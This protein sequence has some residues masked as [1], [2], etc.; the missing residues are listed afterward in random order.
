MCL[1][2]TPSHGRAKAGWPDR[3]YIQQLCADTGCSPEELPEAMDDGELGERGLGISVP[4]ARH[5]DDDDYVLDLKHSSWILI[6]QERNLE[7]K[8]G[9]RFRGW[10]W[11]YIWNWR[12]RANGKFDWMIYFKGG[13]SCFK[14]YEALI[15]PRIEYCTRA[16]VQVSRHRNWIWFGLVW[17]YGI[18]TNAKSI[19]IHI[20]S[21]ISNDSV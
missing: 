13:K 9:M 4:M 14:I 18:S 20:N 7:N 21:S 1:L 11:W 6:E 10:I 8:W 5:H 2:W 16:W 17:F 12:S 15:R 3:T 19:F